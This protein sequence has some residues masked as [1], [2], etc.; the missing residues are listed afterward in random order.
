MN[1]IA[2][3]SR[4]SGPWS[5]SARLLRGQAHLLAG[6]LTSGLIGLVCWSSPGDLLGGLA[7][8]AVLP[9][10]W[11]LMP[12]RRA[13]F[14]CAIAFYLTA[15]PTSY[16]A[17][18]NYFIDWPAA[19]CVA[20]Q[21]GFLGFLV[22]PWLLLPP[23]SEP[24][25]GV[26]TGG[27]LA[28]LVLSAVPPV[29]VISAWHP[30]LS[31]GWVWPAGGWWAL[32]LVFSCWLAVA[33]SPRV[34]TAAAASWALLM[35]GIPTNL[36]YQGPGSTILTPVD[37]SLPRAETHLDFAGKLE[38]ISRRLKAERP[39]G[40]ASSVAVLPENAFEE[41]KD[42]TRAMI[43]FALRRRLAEG[44]ILAGTTFKDS[45]GTWGGVVL[46]ANGTEPQV[47][48]ARQPL[49][50]SLWHPWDPVEHYSATWF[51]PGVLQVGQE[52][53]AI[54][55]C[56]EEFPIFW[57]LVD[58]ALHGATVMA[59]VGNHYWSTTTMHDVVQG[60]HGRAAARL[61]GIPIIRAINRAPGHPLV[62]RPRSTEA[63]LAPPNQ[64]TAATSS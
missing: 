52:R 16:M 51:T 10:I 54:R 58:Q 19:Y 21:I 50:L 26:R 37:L 3:T 17:V 63:G 38:H 33:L 41:W 7:W 25:L 12:T 6:M 46:L 11:L 5:R 53:V 35:I 24:R 60:R 32:G 62:P 30:L 23:S 43:Q 39:A 20:A 40:Q 42:G 9:M 56:S 4:V 2:S 61:F 31:A 13:T 29:G 55:V 28:A 49:V 1:T 47:L 8:M 15:S 45:A 34:R 14:Y 18:R 27:L 44:P 48:R 59:V 36:L 22:L 57:M 64:A